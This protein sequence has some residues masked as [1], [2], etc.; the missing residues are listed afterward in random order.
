MPKAE[1]TLQGD[2]GFPGLAVCSRV[3]SEETYPFLRLDNKDLGK[4]VHGLTD[5]GHQEC[6]VS[7]IGIPHFS[8]MLGRTFG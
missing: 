6:K 3:E 5:P 8:R 4:V 1:T 7:C 2:P